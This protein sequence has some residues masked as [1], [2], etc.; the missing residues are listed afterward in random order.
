MKRAVAVDDAAQEPATPAAHRRLALANSVLGAV[1]VALDGTVLT[2]AQPALRHDLGASFAAVQWTS[3]AYLIAVASLLVFAGRLGDRYGHQRVFAWGVLGFGAASAGIGFAPGVGWVIG[4]RV[5]QGVFGA[6]LQPATLGML[7]A[8][9]PPDRLGM[10]VA[11]RTS[12]IG[13]AAAAGPL[14]GG[15]LVTELGWRAVFFLN[16]APALVMGVPALVVRQ[17]AARRNP[18]STALGLPASGPLGLPATASLDLPGAALLAVALAAL[19]HTLVG[20]PEHGW[21]MTGVL[22]LLTTAATAYALVRHE[23]RAPDPLLPPAVLGSA[24][25]GAA[26]GVLVSA[27]AAMLGALF[28]GS[29]VLQDV[30]GMSPL[31]TSLVALP[32]GVMMVLGAPVAAV[33]LRRWGARPTTLTGTV[34]L[35]T[36]VLVLSR[37]GPGSST[38]VIG[39]GFLL[40]GAGFVTVMV[41][42]TAVVVRHAPPESAGVVGGLQQTAMNVGPTLG[43][44]AAATLVPVGSG[45]AFLLLAAVSALGAPLAGRMPRP[46]GPERGGTRSVRNDEVKHV[47]EP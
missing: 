15:V 11:L 46:A 45:P 43:V 22:G 32:G 12:A 44:A 26:L 1:I 21:T 33:L 42:A 14:V 20:I 41:T 10:P 18:A 37:L 23:R 19:V 24:T 29:H 9:F 16:V 35:T 34:L 39:V 36:G 25:V 6:L 8:S 47:W 27:S 31:R 13:V 7:R 40:L 2:I 28:V 38:V 17:P 4:L 3:T 5:V 30:L